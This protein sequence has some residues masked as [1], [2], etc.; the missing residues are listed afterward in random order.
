MSPLARCADSWAI[1]AEPDWGVGRS[2]HVGC[3]KVNGVGLARVYLNGKRGQLTAAPDLCSGQR[4][5]RTPAPAGECVRSSAALRGRRRN[6]DEKR[7]WKTCTLHATRDRFPAGSVAPSLRWTRHSPSSGS[8]GDSRPRAPGI[9]AGTP[10]ASA[11]RP[12]STSAW[13]STANCGWTRWRRHAGLPFRL[14]VPGACSPPRTS[15]G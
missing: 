12:A 15:S 5:S 10:E 13:R 4:T 8:G 14:P 7:R 3:P 9:G 11:R 6:E 1:E 2:P